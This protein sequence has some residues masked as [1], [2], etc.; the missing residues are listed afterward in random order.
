M[1]TYHEIRLLVRQQLKGH[2]FFLYGWLLLVSLVIGIL[3]NMSVFLG[4]GIGA[5]LLSLAV[6]LVCVVVNNT[7]LFLFLQRVRNLR[8][9]KQDIRYSFS[10]A[11]EQIV[12]GLLLSLFQ[13]FIQMAASVLAILPILYMLVSAFINLLFVYWYACVAWMI[14]DQETH[15]KDLFSKPIQIMKSYASSL[16]LAGGFFVLWNIV[17][18]VGLSLVLKPFLSE[19][20]TLEHALFALVQQAGTHMETIWMLL[21]F[22]IV[23]FLVQYVILVVLYTFLANVYEKANSALN[24]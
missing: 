9:R 3:Q 1:E 13:L 17:S 15:I 19:S 6:S 10:K 22:C 24:R 14:Y 7:L 16:F 23:Y 18:Q 5:T 21:G 11:G 4:D 2:F 12:I 8:F 20:N